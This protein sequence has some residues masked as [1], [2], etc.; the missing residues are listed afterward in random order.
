MP[1]FQLYGRRAGRMSTFLERIR[2]TIR[3]AD[4]QS[5]FTLTVAPPHTDATVRYLRE[6]LDPADWQR[7]DFIGLQERPHG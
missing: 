3:A 1:E 2:D 7:I 6:Q 5:R 4:P